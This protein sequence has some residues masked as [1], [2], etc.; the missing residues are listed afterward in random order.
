[1]LP[2]RGSGFKF[3]RRRRPKKFTRLWR[4]YPSEGCQSNH[5][6]NFL[7]SYMGAF[8]RSKLILFGL[9]LVLE[10]QDFIEDEH[11]YEADDE[12]RTL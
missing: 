7:V 4:V 5:K 9:V 11:E 1:M 10:N 3:Q 8:S 6:R 12:F 2:F